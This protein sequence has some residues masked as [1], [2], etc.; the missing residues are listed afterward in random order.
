LCDGDRRNMDRNGCRRREDRGFGNATTLE[1][2][3]FK[4]VD[5]LPENLILR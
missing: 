1:K 2:S 4:M 5:L 3:L